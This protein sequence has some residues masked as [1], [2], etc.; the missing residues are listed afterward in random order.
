MQKYSQAVGPFCTASAH[1]KALNKMLMK[2]SPGHHFPFLVQLVPVAR[3][4]LRGPEGSCQSRRGR[5]LRLHAMGC[6]SEGHLTS[7]RIL[8]VSTSKTCHL[9]RNI[10]RNP[11]ARCHI[12][13]VYKTYEISS[14]RTVK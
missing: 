11:I 14:Q 12:F 4:H 3:L 1:V 2:L 6:Y 9:K 10:F 13:N 8:P 5:L 7:G